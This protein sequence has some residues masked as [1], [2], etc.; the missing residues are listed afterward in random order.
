MSFQMKKL[1]GDYPVTEAVLSG[2]GVQH[3]GN[4]SCCAQEVAHEDACE[5]AGMATDELA[6][7]LDVASQHESL[8]GELRGFT[9][10][11]LAQIINYIVEKHHAFARQELVCLKSLLAKVCFG[12]GDRH[13]EL[14]HIQNL[15]KHLDEELSAHMQREERALFPYLV[16][17][18]EAH[19]CRETF[20]R[21]VFGTTGVLA[22]LMSH[23][24]ERESKVLGEIRRASS[25]YTAPEGAC[26]SYRLLYRT[27]KDF[28]LDLRQHIYLEDK[29]LFARAVKMEARVSPHQLRKPPQFIA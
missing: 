7:S 28:E 24:H 17:M 19:N 3:A 18:E 25:D 12:H 2:G 10:A 23:E 29:V 15:F 5:R 11:P 1:K 4:K 9:L 13:P 26:P 6:H 22:H 16:Q 14:L 20:R 27:L 21:P 8:V